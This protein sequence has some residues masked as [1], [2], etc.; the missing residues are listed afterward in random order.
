MRERPLAVERRSLRRFN[1]AMD[2]FVGRGLVGRIGLSF[3]LLPR[4]R[5]G[6]KEVAVPDS[7]ATRHHHTRV[8]IEGVWRDVR[9]PFGD[10]GMRQA[11]R[12]SAAEEGLQPPFGR[13]R[14]RAA[15][16]TP[17]ALPGRGPLAGRRP[18]SLGR[19]KEPGSLQRNAFHNR[20]QG[21]LGS[22]QLRQLRRNPLVGTQECAGLY[23]EGARTS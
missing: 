11:L 2:I 22:T 4:S 15:G 9:Q 14:P 16:P 8:G 10:L 5:R 23:L 21:S 20:G 12:T 17:A 3:K 6:G 7:L 18:R 13:V 19:V 1:I